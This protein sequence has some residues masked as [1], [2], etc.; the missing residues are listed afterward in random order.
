M[1]T[2]RDTE[3]Q[4]IDALAQK[5]MDDAAADGGGVLGKLIGGFL[6]CYICCGMSCFGGAVALVVVG[7]N[8]LADDG[9]ENASNSESPDNG[10]LLLILGVVPIIAFA[11]C[12]TYLRAQDAGWC[13]PDNLSPNGLA[14]KR[15][16]A[17]RRQG[18]LYEHEEAEREATAETQQIIGPVGGNSTPP[19]VS[20]AAMRTSATNAESNRDTDADAQG[21]DAPI[22]RAL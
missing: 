1:P 2:D 7:V 6:V 3:Q 17:M 4:Q 8:R 18:R 11:V 13:R 9:T 16:E 21:A 22:G 10:L 19:S 14:A 5:A 15:K 12:I 20:P